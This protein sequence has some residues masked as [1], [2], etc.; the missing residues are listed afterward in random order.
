MRKEDCFEL[1]II[2]RTHGTKGGLVLF[3]DV[4]QPSDYYQLKSVLV[5]LGD[6]LIPYFITSLDPGA[7]QQVFVKFEDIDTQE[8]ANYLQ[9][10]TLW[11]PLKNLPK[12]E[13]KKF[14]YHEVKGFMVIDIN[15]GEI[16]PLTEIIDLSVNPLF[17]V[18]HEGKEILIP[19]NDKFI[20][21][22]KRKERQ[23]IIEMPDGLLE[24]YLQV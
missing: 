14:Y 9:G 20:V 6:E 8:D 23:L 1:G 7:K 15:K 17:S 12:L 19:V 24:L 22:I 3:L 2:S 18:D 11:L 10:C 16:G 4:D 5:E 13:G 21:E